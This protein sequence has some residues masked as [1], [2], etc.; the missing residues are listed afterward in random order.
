MTRSIKPNYHYNLK[1][2]SNPAI[3]PD[4]SMVAF[5]L[6]RFDKKSHAANSDLFATKADGYGNPDQL[7]TSGNA[8]NPKWSPDGRQIAYI[9]L[10]D[11]GVK[12]IFVQW[13]G[14]GASEPARLTHR[15]ADVDAIVWSPNGKRIAFRSLVLGPDELHAIRSDPSEPKI[16]VA[17]RIRYRQDGA[18]WRGDSFYHLFVLDIGSGEVAQITGREGDDGPPVWSPD[19]KR[20]AFISDRND[21]RDFISKTELFVR[22]ADG[23]ALEQWSGDLFMVESI[24]WS[25]DSKRS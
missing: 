17:R 6:H 21:E 15:L 10:D 4:G 16:R 18:G 23:S 11:S 7:T 5:I 19:G 22:N 13:F 25:P 1:T 12:Q 14:S 3:S 20:I 2:A 8:A 24:A 9:D